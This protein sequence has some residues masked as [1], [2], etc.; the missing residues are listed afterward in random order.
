[1]L[2]FTIRELNSTFHLPC[3]KSSTIV[4]KGFK[5]RARKTI[6]PLSTWVVALQWSLNLFYIFQIL[7][8]VKMLISLNC[9]PLMVKL[10]RM[11]FGMSTVFNY[12]YICI[13][14]PPTL[15]STILSDTGSEWNPG[16]GKSFESET[17]FMWK[18]R[19][20]KKSSHFD[21][22]SAI[23]TISLLAIHCWGLSNVF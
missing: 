21:G 6:L 1:M 7:K 11:H 23:C 5:G 18:R 22:G 12:S 4:T 13:Y 15:V 16:Q 2:N 20:L 19:Q 17:G 8:M 9:R 10:P 3:T 14:A